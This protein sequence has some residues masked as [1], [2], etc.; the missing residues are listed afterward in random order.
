MPACV[1]YRA[2]GCAAGV[3]RA[4][5]GM[6]WSVSA[7]YTNPVYSGY[8]A[9]P[10]VLR[11]GE[12]YFAYG[13][14]STPAGRVFEVLR[15]DD[16]VRWTS[17]GGALEPLADPDAT[18]YWAPEVLAH[19]GSYFMYYSV[20]QE[21]RN[22][23]IRVAVAE[24]PAGPFR[25]CGATLTP[26]ER[27]AIDAHPFRDADGELYLF[28]ARDVL[29]GDRV[30]TSLAV[31]RL[32]DM[33]TLEGNPR[34]V[35]RATRDW[36]LFRAQRSMYGSVYDWF[37]LEGPFVRR[38]GDRYYCFY[39]GGAWEEHNYG[40]SYGVADH[41]LGPWAEPDAPGPTVLASVEGRVIGPGHNSIVTA[42]NGQDFLV[43]HAWDPART[44]RRMCIDPLLW[45]PEGPT[46]DGP[47]FSP[48]PAPTR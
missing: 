32:L 25:D 28:Y 43:Y 6:K 11:V 9:D 33:T 15:S 12:E 17:V 2:N 44:G 18:T 24:H 37:T 40:V 27:F 3:R 8:F 47:S 23:V 29:E 45:T 22:H 48:R 5:P 7:S 21:D 20:G 13:T 34:T 41:P 14:G 19:D 39:S 10:F 30:G 46:C 36:Q 31:D 16:L 26:H 1:P 38:H 35:L 42:P 4:P